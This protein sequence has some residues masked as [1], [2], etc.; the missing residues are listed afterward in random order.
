[1]KNSLL[2]CAFF[3]CVFNVNCMAAI[4]FVTSVTDDGNDDKANLVVP[5]LTQMGD[6]LITQ[7]TF[8]NRSGSDGVTTP[9]GWTLI[10]PQD[11]D[12]DVFQS[13]YYK[14]ATAVDAGTSYE[15]DFDGSGNRRYILGMS[16]FRGVD[17]SNP[18]AAENSAKSS[19]NSWSLTAP[20]VTTTQVNSMLVAT[21]TSERGNHSLSTPFGMTEIYDNEEH[22]TANGLTSMS[23]YESFPGVAASGSRVATLTPW[24]PD[25]GI[26]HLI[27]LNEGSAAPEITSVVTACGSLN[28]LD[29]LFSQDLDPSTA[30]DIL[31]YDLANNAL[32]SLG[33]ASAVL[34]SPDTVTLTL[35]TDINDL[36]AYT[37]TVNNVEN[38]AGD[39]IAADST[40][41]FMLSCGLNCITDNFAGPGDLSDSWS[42]G[43]SSGTFGDPTIITD[44]RLRLTNNSGNVSTVATLLNQFPGADNRIEVEFDYYGYDGSGADG[45]AFN[46]SDA[47]ILPA[48][49]AFGGSLGYAQKTGINGFSGGWLGVGI[50]EY[51]NF[52]SSGE[53]RSGGPGRIT[54]SV[55]LRG[56]GIGTADYPYLT[57]TGSLT[58]GIDNSGSST[59]SPG[60]RYKIVIDHTAGGS[61][62]MA[63]VARDTG[64]GYVNIVPEFN[65]F[66]AYPDQAAV[67]DN[68]VVSFTGSTGG[69]TNIHEIGD[70]K[71]CAAQPIQTFSQV[72]HYDISHTTPGLTCE[73]SEVTITAHDA[74]H[75]PINVLSDTSIVV[76]TIPTVSAIVTSPVTML[77]GTSTVSIYLQQTSALLNIDIDVSDGSFTDDE[78][79]AEDPRISFLDTAFRFYADGSNTG[80]IPINT[81]I[82][83]KPTT[84]VPDDQSLV[85]RSI[86]TNTDTGACEAGLTGSQTVSF[87]YTCKDPDS[88]SSAQLSVTANETKNIAGTDDGN[89]FAYTNLD[90][91]FDGTGSA[92]FSFTFL[93]AGKIQLHANLIVPESSPDPAFT[94]IGSSNEFIVRPFAFELLFAA[95]S[96]ADTAAGSKFISAGSDFPVQVRA[97]NWQAADDTNDDGIVDVDAITGVVADLSSNSTTINFGEE[98]NANVSNLVVTHALE[99][100]LPDVLIPARVGTFSAS[101]TTP[102]GSGSHFNNGITPLISSPSAVIL[103]WSEV[104]IVDISVM[105]EDYLSSAGSGIDVVGNSN[106]VGRFYPH[107][108]TLTASDVTDSCGVFS[109]MGQPSIDVTYTLEAQNAANIKT[110]NYDGAFVKI[111]PSTDITFVVEND[112]Q[113]TNYQARLTGLGSTTWANGEYVYS[114]GSVGFSRANLGLLDGPY[115]DLQIGIQISD[116]DGDVSV[117]ENLDMEADSSIVCVPLVNCDAKGLDVADTLDLRFGQLKLSN[118]FGPETFALDMAVQTEYFDG[119]SF[120]LNTDDNCTALFDTDPPLSPVALSWTDNL[121][122]GETTASLS[123]GTTMSAGLGTFSFGAAGLGNEGSVIYQYDTGTYLPWLNTEND[124]DADFADNPFGKITFGQFRGNDRMIYWR[125]VVR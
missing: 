107:H 113:G 87:A 45:I 78:G 20:S 106:N 90:M 109:Y 41:D 95:N 23:A 47:S 60:H 101:I 44:G 18:I 7:V 29:I 3:L 114:I 124:D 22:N 67:P 4:S 57:G 64:S 28:T 50:D 70:F 96:A 6:V 15:W 10:A 30:Q 8:R 88:C 112:N 53:G 56:S 32:S 97:V 46:F 77:T 105:L 104:G 66:T 35:T 48:A 73:G 33:I 92:P 71:V 19:D 120:I 76:T 17:N 27:A 93:D 11:Q 81:Q 86:R 26:G 40:S 59:A 34:S 74:N 121:S 119:T 75:D 61:V 98:L 103:N 118:V 43:N 62:A 111:S 5:A 13:A 54:D 99:L 116:N 36:T 83:G 31:N 69:A 58:P 123:S 79:S 85:L 80:V 25:Y 2:L 108:F 63:S 49:G 42:V 94:L 110:V 115:N 39:A 51:G 1:M 52:S 9:A 72:D 100:P 24:A 91:L 68:W 82:S 122:A 21:Y 102:G 65:V 84:E 12:S 37:L 14:V 125:E 89:S 117:L 38:L 16:V 55:A